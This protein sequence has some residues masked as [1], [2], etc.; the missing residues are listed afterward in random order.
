VRNASEPGVLRRFWW[1]GTQKRRLAA[2]GSLA[3]LSLSGTVLVVLGGAQAPPSTAAVTRFPPPTASTPA[4]PVVAVRAVSAV[5]E[6]DGLDTASGTPVRVRVVDIRSTAP[7][8][9]AE[10][11]AFA[12]DALLGKEVRLV[13]TGGRSTDERLPAHVRLPTGEDFALA[14]LTAGAAVAG[15]EVTP[16]LLTAESAARVNRLGLWANACAESQAPSPPPASESATTTTTAGTTPPPDRT[17]APTSDPPDTTATS[18]PT[19]IQQGVRV[20]KPCSPEGATGISRNGREVTCRR[21]LVG[22][23]RWGVE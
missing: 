3:L 1:R 21:T 18:R 7:C 4:D 19:D 14:A 8:W 5:D 2:V 10:S 15:A 17:S 12:R 16:E 20:G 6:F 9:Q 13:G 22:G 23:L 11:L